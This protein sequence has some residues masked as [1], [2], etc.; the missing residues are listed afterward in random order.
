MSMLGELYSIISDTF[1]TMDKELD[2]PFENFTTETRLSDLGIDR[3]TFSV[4]EMNIES[5]LNVSLPV[6]DDYR[7]E[8]IGDVMSMIKSSKQMYI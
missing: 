6:D 3:F 4:L 7:I 1:F 8:T 2:V 5:R